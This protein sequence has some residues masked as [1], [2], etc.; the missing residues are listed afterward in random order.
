MTRSGLPNRP[1][2]GRKSRRCEALD[3]LLADTLIYA[4]STGIDSKKDYIARLL[5][6][7]NFT[8]G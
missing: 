4:H 5:R 1:D 6:D 7:D 3:A 2:D 8:W